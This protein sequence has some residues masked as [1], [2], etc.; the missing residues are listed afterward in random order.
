MA[1]LIAALERSNAELDSF[2]HIAS[3]DLKA[4]LRVI[5]NATVWLEEDLEEHLTDDTRESMEMVRSRVARMERLLDDLL[6]HSRIGRVTSESPV[7]TG[8]A[9]VDAIRDLVDLP[10]GFTL[11]ATPAMLA[12]ALPRM[13]ILTVLLNLVSNALKHHDRDTGEVVMDATETPDSN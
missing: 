3:H 10:Q 13:P 11:R 4:P 5:E 1:D 12:V 7:V 9:L 6:E 8:E 2:A